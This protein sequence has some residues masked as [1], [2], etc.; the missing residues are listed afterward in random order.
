MKNTNNEQAQKTLNLADDECPHPLSSKPST[1]QE[2]QTVTEKQ[3]VTLLSPL[4]KRQPIGRN[5]DFF[6]LGG[7][8][9]LAVKF[10]VSVI[11]T[12]GVRIPPRLF[13]KGTTVAE[14]AQTIDSLIEEK[15]QLEE[16]K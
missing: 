10:T 14:L 5:D 3:V 1:F 11:E 9:L 7:N 8:S 13:Y 4:L 2:P 15:Q 6:R 16:G 12:F